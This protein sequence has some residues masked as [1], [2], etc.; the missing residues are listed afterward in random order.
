MTLPVHDDAALQGPVAGS[1]AAGVDLPRALPFLLNLALVGALGFHLGGWPGL[2]AGV[3]ALL[4]LFGFFVLAR[5]IG[6]RRDRLAGLAE[7]AARLLRPVAGLVLLPFVAL[8]TIAVTL[9]LSAFDRTLGRLALPGISPGLSPRALVR[10]GLGLVAG[11]FS[12]ENLPM[13][14]VNALLLLVFGCLAIG[15]EVA[16]YAALAAVPVMICTMMMVAVE[17][18]REPEDGPAGS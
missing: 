4:A 12:A 9:A 14:A 11:F 17:S 2:A 7:G 6:R 5:G 13:T 8:L 15:I 10:R 3:G 16:F 1:A 18:S